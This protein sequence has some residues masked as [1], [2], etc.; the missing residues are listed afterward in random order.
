M[1]NVGGRNG[2]GARRSPEHYNAWSGRTRFRIND[3]LRKFNPIN[4]KFV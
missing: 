3:T 2:W 1:F 4:T